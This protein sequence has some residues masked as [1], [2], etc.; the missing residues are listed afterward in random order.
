[1]ASGLGYSAVSLIKTYLR[2]WSTNNEEDLA[3]RRGTAIG[4]SCAAMA[5]EATT[6]PPKLVIPEKTY[7][8]GEQSNQGDVIHKFV[9]KNEGGSLLKII[10][11]RPSCGC[12]IANISPRDIPPGQSGTIE[13]KLSLRGR[14][15]PQHKRITVESNDPVAKTVTLMLR[16]TAV[17]TP[18]G[19]GGEA[20]A[21]CVRAHPSGSGSGKCDRYRDECTANSK[22]TEVSTDSPLL[23]VSLET[24]QEGKSYKVKVATKPPIPFGAINA[25]VV[26]KTDNAKIPEIVIPVYGS[27]VNALTVAPQ[28]IRLS[29]NASAAVTRYVLVRPERRVGS[30]WRKLKRPIPRSRSTCLPWAVPGIG[31]SSATSPAI[32]SSTIPR[33]RSSPMWRV[34]A[35]S[36]SRSGSTK[37]REA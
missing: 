15:G 36:P 30:R 35:R 20:S 17:D 18:A 22:V 27:V 21:R 31:S 12:T 24:V 28:E 6:P 34:R 1:M 32:P 10:N 2:T 5:Q 16:G 37:T 25:K 13:A 4:L 7:D 8:F 3:D 14:K 33:S 19:S 26:A 23:D 9:V 11:V 29:Q